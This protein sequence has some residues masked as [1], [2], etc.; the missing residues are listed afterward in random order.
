MVIPAGPIYRYQLFVPHSIQLTHIY[1]VFHRCIVMCLNG[2][3]WL[4]LV[5]SGHWIIYPLWCHGTCGQRWQSI[6]VSASPNT[7]ERTIVFSFFLLDSV[8]M[9]MLILKPN[10]STRAYWC[11]ISQRD[12]IAVIYRSNRVVALIDDI[13]SLNSLLLVY[14][15][16]LCSL[17]E[18]VDA[19]TVLAIDAHL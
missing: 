5:G 4:L 7:P 9:M 17:Q 3:G 19:R 14:I 2:L 16:E 11:A 18:E 8:W 6:R 12:T 1:I 15:L 10:L 13:L